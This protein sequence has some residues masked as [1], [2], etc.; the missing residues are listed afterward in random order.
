MKIL[1]VGGYGY[2][3]VN[4]YQHLKLSYDIDI[5]TNKDE[6]LEKLKNKKYEY[7]IYLASKTNPVTA[8]KDIL[9]DESNVKDALD[10]I[11]VIKKLETKFLYFSS[12]GTVYRDNNIPHT[13]DEIC[14][15]VNQYGLTKIKIEKVIK[16]TLIKKNKYMILRVSNPY[17]GHGYK[18]KGQGFIN[19]SINQINKN[20]PIQIYGDGSSVRDYIYMKDLTEIIRLIISKNFLN[21][22]IINVSTGIGTNL[23][24]ILKIMIKKINKNV[25]VQYI[26]NDKVYAKFNVLN[27]Q[28]LLKFLGDY[29]FTTIQ[30]GI[31]ELIL[32]K[33]N[34]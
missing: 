7:V 26:Q 19:F 9:L 22:Q 24:D 16:D 28:R 4:I 23:N 5:S 2:I 30:D 15:P 17:G 34:L 6:T 32:E 31:E 3:G 21:N 27:N 11:E 12:G 1:V 20:L 10:V 13:E 29:K 14:E 18:E 25:T 8:S 33:I